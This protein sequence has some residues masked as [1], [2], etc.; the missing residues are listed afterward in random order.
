LEVSTVSTNNALI[1][2]LAAEHLMAR[3]LR[4][5]AYCGIASRTIDPWSSQRRDALVEHLRRHGFRCHVYST[6]YSPGQSWERLQEQLAEWLV[7]LPK[8]VGLMAANDARARHVLQACRR[9]EV[10][11]PD[12]VA[13]IG[14]DNDELICNLATPPLTSIVQGTEEI[15]YRAAV[16]L[17][18]MMRRRKRKTTHVTIDPVTVVTR[19][20][21]DLVATQDA[22]TANA[23]S[24]I[25][26]RAREGIQVADVA[27]HVGA[28]RST[29]D[30]RFRRLVGRTV[31][32]EIQRTRLTAAQ[33][34]LVTT[35]L[36]AEE[37]AR[38]AGFRN[39]QYMNVVFRRALRQTPGQY[40]RG[41][42]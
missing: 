40:R 22:I 20:S 39:A 41:A 17:D 42:R 37:I 28:S 12:E 6:R 1:A 5:F 34:L 11:V 33:Q 23:L 35:D 26:Q 31:H 8:P 38:R 9:S 29:L 24:Y 13:V 30:D 27:K 7:K 32:S 21:T 15:G 4:N 16:M 19:E 3:G 25:R 10:S 14:V 2:V 18:Q 36:P